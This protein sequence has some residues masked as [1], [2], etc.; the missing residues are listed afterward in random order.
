MR[1][2]YIFKIKKEMA[3]I[4]RDT[5]YNLYRTI[6]HLYYVDE[7]N[8]GV[9]FKLYN[10]IF[11]TFN[12][13][14]VDKKIYSLFRNY[15]YYIYDNE[16][17]MIINKYRPENTYLKVYKS[18]IILKSDII[19]PTLLLNYLMS[20]DLFVCDFKNKD[21]FWLNELVRL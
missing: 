15:K 17:H 16:K 12:K 7:Y 10:D 9:S 5:P 14:Y 6:E 13:E 4:T 18:H 21:Y 8:M 3:I 1:T 19:K 11:S 2:F 20:E